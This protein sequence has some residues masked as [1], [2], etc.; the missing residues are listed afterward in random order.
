VGSRAG[1]D[2]ILEKCFKIPT[3]RTHIT[4]CGRGGL[5]IFLEA[6]VHISSIS[7]LSS[8]WEIFLRCFTWVYEIVDCPYSVDHCEE[9]L[10]L[11]VF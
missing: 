4:Y 6:P 10:R 1:L 8:D 11:A 7:A 2:T 3:G 9:V 5:K